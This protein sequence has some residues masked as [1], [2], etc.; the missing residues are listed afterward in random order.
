MP[1]LV[2]KGERMG[3]VSRRLKRRLIATSAG[4]GGEYTAQRLDILAGDGEVPSLFGAFFTLCAYICVCLCTL[5]LCLCMSQM[6][7]CIA[8]LMCVCVCVRV[9]AL[10]S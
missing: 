9:R 7:A 4:G 2:R 1:E 6:S 5:C 10:L 3:T 8:A